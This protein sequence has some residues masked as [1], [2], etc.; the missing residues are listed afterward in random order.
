MFAEAAESRICREDAWHA[1]SATIRA[2]QVCG[3]R[4]F[5]ARRYTQSC[6][7]TDA[8]IVQESAMVKSVKSCAEYWAAIWKWI[9]ERWRDGDRRCIDGMRACFARLHPLNPF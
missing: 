4:E 3:C 5:E 7:N 1:R 9:E 2:L 8:T 6:R